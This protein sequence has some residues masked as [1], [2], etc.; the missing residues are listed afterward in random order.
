MRDLIPFC[1]QQIR[2]QEDAIRSYK[3]F[4]ALLLSVALAIILYGLV[5]GIRGDSSSDII[6]VGAGIVTVAFAGLPYKEITPRRQRIG[7][8]ELVLWN[9]NRFDSLSPEERARVNVMV[10]ELIKSN[11]RAP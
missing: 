5:G 9:L 8:I 4:V 6:K 7:S 11:W 3:L 1:K 2:I 10:D